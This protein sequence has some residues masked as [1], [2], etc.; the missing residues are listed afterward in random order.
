M[1][2]KKE[3]SAACM[4]GASMKILT[5]M[6]LRIL[7]LEDLIVRAADM[8]SYDSVHLDVL[9]EARRILGKKKEAA[10]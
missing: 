10:R 1:V 6:G 3:G 9:R 5:T 8:E 7:E 2:P 4:D